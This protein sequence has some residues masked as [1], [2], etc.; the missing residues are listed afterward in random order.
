MRDPVGPPCLFRLRLR[1]AGPS[2]S[3]CRNIELSYGISV[4]NLLVTHASAFELARP[5]PSQRSETASHPFFV[6]APTHRSWFASERVLIKIL[7]CRDV[8]VRD[9]WPSAHASIGWRHVPKDSVSRRAP[10]STLPTRQIRQPTTGSVNR[11]SQVDGTRFKRNF[12]VMM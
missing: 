4:E 7:D 10:T 3:R 11:L 2:K 5:A 1:H 9:A 12:G 6:T 8:T